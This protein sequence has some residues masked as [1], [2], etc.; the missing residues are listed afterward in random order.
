MID[1][2][3][4]QDIEHQLKHR[5]RMVILDPKGQCDF[6]LPLLEKKK[7][8]V[9]KTD[10]ALTEQWQT[11]KEEL[12]LRYEAETKHN[13]NNVIFY[14]TRK[15]NKLSFLFD[16]CFTYGCLDLSNPSEWLKKKLFT[17]TGLQIQM[18]NTNLLTAAKLSIGKDI[19]WWKKILQDL[20]ELVS[21]D[22]MLLPFLHEPQTYLN[23]IDANVR[24]LFEEKLF[25]LLGQ[26]YMKK[27]PKTLAN[28]VVKKLF[29]GLIHNNVSESLL[30][31]Y[32][33]WADSETN[34]P[35]LTNYISTYKIDKSADPWL[36]HP[37][38]CF[39]VL[40]KKAIQQLTNNLRDKTFVAEKLNTIKVRA[41]SNKVKS[42][43]PTWW[44]HIITLMEF[45]SKPLTNCDNFNKVI[46]FYTLHF[47][48]V[49]RA[50]RN[51]Y[52]TFL[53]DTAIIRPLQEHYENLNHELLQQWFTYSKEYKSDQQGYL[54]NLLKNTTQKIAVIVGDGIRYEIADFVTTTMEK[55]FT[56]EK[57][58]MLA[59]MPSETEHN[60]SALYVGDNEVLPVHKDREKRLIKL[61]GKDI[62]YM[63]LDALHYGVS[64]DLL[65]LTYKDIDKTGEELQHGAIKL[66]E[67]FEQVLKERITLLLNMG[68]NQVILISDHGF[69][70]TGLLN[71]ADKIEPTANGKKE[72]HERFIHT[73]NKQ[74]KINWICF[75]EKYKEYN[76]V[77]VS[78]SHR[79]FRSKGVYGYSH[80]GFT[81]QEIIIP[82][83]IFQKEKTT[84]SSLKV[85]IINKKELVEVTGELFGIKLQAASL[86]APDLFS[87]NRKV[88]I[89]LY[90][91]NVNY[92][93]SN[94]ID[95]EPG[96]NVSLEFS[97]E[98]NAEIKV[99]LLDAET[100]E[101]LDDLTIKK[102]KVRD[103]GGLQ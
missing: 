96:K 31:I 98:G 24:R 19:A 91:G 72:V 71:E 58:I 82:K 47:A 48:R 70:L 23:S 67:E 34:R 40:D 100:R 35:S 59:G 52:A 86:S 2:W 17:N 1:K 97:L 60:M 89:L 85:A 61:A 15:Q 83:F 95:M 62:T 43:V 74:S 14:V 65:V 41:N 26:P 20:E 42:I 78:K 55:H 30:Q 84:T 3:F 54:V 76:Y 94:I 50:I 32:Y 36:A 29:D 9:L 75:E 49:D 93:T 63:N 28:E 57:Q 4:L 90:K 64:A 81:P 11:V 56:V 27:P 6:L 87:F 13:E 66:F 37:D 44:E 102:S 10:N 99:V 79:P 77:Y 68:Y 25:E 69:V 22:D 7:Y 18:D 39:E 53:Q 8:T 92:S 38:H 80:G 101:Q 21:I 88:Q 16:Y 45:D 46:D 103:F 5:K 12:F 51:L 33:H 73:E